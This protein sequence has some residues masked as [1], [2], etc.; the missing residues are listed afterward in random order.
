[1]PSIDR[2]QFLRGQ[3]Q[4]QA[5]V[6]PP[7]S[8]AEALFI[9]SCSGCGDCIKAC[10][11]HILQAG[12]GHFPN[13]D[14]KQGECTFCG[15]CVNACKTSALDHSIQPA[16]SFSIQIDKRCLPYSGIE[17]RACCDSCTAEAIAFK[18]TLG[19]PAQPELNSDSCTGCGACFTSCPVNALIITPAPRNLNQ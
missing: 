3:W 4:G 10:S 12:R 1:M 11:E 18:P 7:W 19:G 5:P 9:E 14:F 15:E 13:I 2:T 16:F 8:I 17:C 6:R